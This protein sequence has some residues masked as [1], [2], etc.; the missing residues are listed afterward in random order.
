M[1]ENK[2]KMEKLLL[3]VPEAADVLGVGISTMYEMLAQGQLSAVRFGRAVR[4]RADDLRE[5]VNKH[6][7]K[8]V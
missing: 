6:S 8:R 7:E 2:V 3:R 1:M 5:W 4:I